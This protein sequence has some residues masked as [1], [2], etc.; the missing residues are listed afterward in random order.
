MKIM[1]MKHYKFLNGLQCSTLYICTARREILRY[2]RESLHILLTI[3]FWRIQ[4]TRTYS[5]LVLV[6]WIVYFDMIF[7]HRPSPL[8]PHR[9]PHRGTIYILIPIR[10]WL[11]FMEI[12]ILTWFLVYI[13]SLSRNYG[14][15]SFG[16]KKPLFS[17]LT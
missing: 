6:L 15:N 12:N 10:I 4:Y 13:F 9:R 16:K 8:T 2:F 5:Q 3:Y 14:W 1:N 17:W 7:S 11:M